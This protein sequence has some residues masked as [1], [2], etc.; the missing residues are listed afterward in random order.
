MTLN[1]AINTLKAAGIENP[2]FDARELFC[3]F[4]SFKRHEIIS[5]NMSLDDTVI[6]KPIAERAMRK[7]LQYIIGSVGFYREN[8]TVT[9]DCLI[10]RQDTEILV[11]FAVKNIPDSET[12]IDICTGSG[13]IAIST[14]KNT[15]N[16][17]CTAIDISAG[18][19][20]VAKKNAE[21]NGVSGRVEFL[22]CDAL[23]YTPDKKIFA[24]LSNPP[25]VT[26]EEYQRLDAELYCEPKIALVGKDSGL[27]FYKKIVPL[28]KEKLKPCGFIAF[29]IGK[30]QARALEQIA[31]EN[32]MSA[33]IIKDFSGLARVAVLRNL[34]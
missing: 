28:V 9:P 17:S 6:S 24:V 19:I 12:F 2:E 13:C 21:D 29:E 1:E 34:K 10:P 26:E 11:D 16:T 31:E 8:Y 4:G 15:K 30:N 18:A 20:A 14:L 25:Y 5:R 3:H 7:P 23:K 33:E 32:S 22:L 27:E